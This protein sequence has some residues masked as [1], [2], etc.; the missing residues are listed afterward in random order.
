M[1][2]PRLVRTYRGH[3]GYV[4]SVVVLGVLSDPIDYAIRTDH[5]H[6]PGNHG[7][8]QGKRNDGFT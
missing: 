2:I 8:R 1:L 4:H 6:G 7:H 3:W 5:Y